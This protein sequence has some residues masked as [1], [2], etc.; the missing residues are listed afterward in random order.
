MSG[1]T[2]KPVVES[3]VVGAAAAVIGPGAVAAIVGSRTVTVDA[4]AAL[5]IR[6]EERV[7]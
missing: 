4:I 2:R 3:L 5:G 1:R 6:V 7:A